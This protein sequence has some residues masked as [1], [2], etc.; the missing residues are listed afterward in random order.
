MGNP[1]SRISARAI[2]KL[3]RSWDR[4][5]VTCEFGQGFVIKGYIPW[6]THTHTRD[7]CDALPPGLR[8]VEKGPRPGPTTSTVHCYWQGHHLVHARDL[9]EIPF[10][11]LFELANRN[12][13][14]LMRRDGRTDP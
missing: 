11:F 13:T 9:K 4:L 12:S 5:A 1:G 14:A 6:Y 3:N 2:A 8:T 10:K 7:M